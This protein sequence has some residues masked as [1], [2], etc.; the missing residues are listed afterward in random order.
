MIRTSLSCVVLLLVVKF[1]YSEKATEF[2]D[3]STLDLSNVVT[4]KSTVEI[5]QNFVAFSEYMNFTKKGLA[6]G[7]IKANFCN[8]VKIFISSFWTNR[9]DLK[10]LNILVKIS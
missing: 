9:D 4:V 6:K 7:K 8:V 2:W 5:S 3:I 10:L 1:I